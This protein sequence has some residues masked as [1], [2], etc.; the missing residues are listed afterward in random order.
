MQATCTANKVFDLRCT[1]IDPSKESSGDVLLD[2][3][4]LQCMYVNVHV[5]YLRCQVISKATLADIEFLVYRTP[6]WTD[7]L[8]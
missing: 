2:E 8:Q 1:F 5:T 6:S 7:S 4:Y 3:N